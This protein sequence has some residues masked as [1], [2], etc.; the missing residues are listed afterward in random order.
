MQHP[1]FIPRTVLALALLAGTVLAAPHATAQITLP[2]GNAP[3]LTLFGDGVQIYDSAANP[4][5]P[6]TFIWNFTAPQANLFTDA[7]ETTLFGTHFA[8]PTWMSNADGSSVV[9]ARIGSQASATPNSIPQLLLKAQSHSGTGIFAEVTYIQRLNTVGGLAPS[10]PPTG[11][12]QEFRSPYTATYRFAQAVPEP[13]A[14][15]MVVSTLLGG[16]SL[17]WLRRRV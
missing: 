4:N 7:S 3:F 10:T 17:L 14:L 9:G 1:L 11:F 13:G 12:D 8:G 2:Q 6:G 5:T 16:V 15:P